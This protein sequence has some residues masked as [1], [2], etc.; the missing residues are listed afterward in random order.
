MAALTCFSDKVDV[1]LSSSLICDTTLWIQKELL[2]QFLS[3]TSTNCT[4][5]SQIMHFDHIE[6]IFQQTKHMYCEKKARER[7]REHKE[8]YKGVRGN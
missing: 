8:A 7:E 5:S 3:V 1:H 6:P 4:T 2:P